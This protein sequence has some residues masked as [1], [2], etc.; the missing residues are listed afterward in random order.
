MVTRAAAIKVKEAFQELQKA[1]EEA[2][3]CDR[4]VEAE[5]KRVEEKGTMPKLVKSEEEE[6][7]EEEEE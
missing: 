7:E 5:K 2:E 3:Q 1:E 6:E 4:L